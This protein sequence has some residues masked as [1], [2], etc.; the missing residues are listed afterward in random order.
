MLTAVN[1]GKTRPM[2][3]FDR[4]LRMCFVHNEVTD[5]FVGNER[6][7]GQVFFVLDRVIPLPVVAGFLS[8]DEFCSI[9]HSD[10]FRVKIN[11]IK[12]FGWVNV[13]GGSHLFLEVVI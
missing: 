4:V 3:R 10:Y 1:F 11:N 9:E 12:L 2:N 7:L 6:Q 5:N 8:Y 13:L